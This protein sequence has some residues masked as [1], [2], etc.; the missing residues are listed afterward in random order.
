MPKQTFFNLPQKKRQKIE[1]AALDEFSEYGFDNSNMNRIVAQS[2]IAKGSFYQ[3]FD[4]KKDLYLHLIDTLVARKA[5]L[6]E[7]LI[8][9]FRQNSFSKNL[10]EL[11]R[12][13]LEFADSDPKYYRL[14]EDSA[15]KNPA[16]IQEFVDKYNPMAVDIY[17]Q[18]LNYANETGE[19]HKDV[20]IPLTTAFI[21]SLIN[22]TT[23]N[24][25]SN[26][27]SVVQRNMV[28]AELIGFI[29]RAVLT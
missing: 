17:A 6:F 18:L 15:Y 23:M 2:Q 7:T 12:I 4:D 14:S 8:N 29:E 25:I 26:A 22:Q 9:N 13:G 5:S 3:Y 1:Q 16:F 10:E 27:V 21:S 20:N 19:L 24:L 11:F 28:I